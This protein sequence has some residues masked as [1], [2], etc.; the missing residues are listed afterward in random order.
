[1]ESEKSLEGRGAAASVLRLT[2]HHQVSVLLGTGAPSAL[3]SPR[4]RG[5]GERRG[6]GDGMGRGRGG[7]GGWSQV[8]ASSFKVSLLVSVWVP[9][10][11]LIFN[12]I[13]IRFYAKKNLNVQER[14]L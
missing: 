12:M 10:L 2:L 9:V 5:I 3:L 14:Q 8:A 11:L 7:L 4:V 6:E 13:F 1:M